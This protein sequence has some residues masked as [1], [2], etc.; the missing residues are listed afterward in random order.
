MEPA[1]ANHTNTGPAQTPPTHRRKTAAPTSPPPEPPISPTSSPLRPLPL[2]RTT[3][4]TVSLKT[5]TEHGTE[6]KSVTVEVERAPVAEV[7]EGD[8][9]EVTEVLEIKEVPQVSEVLEVKKV[10]IVPKVERK[11][12]P[13]AS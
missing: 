1:V 9:P 5:E 8:P 2:L 10:P 12:Y 6:I 3:S 7:E 13:I 4:A 11:V